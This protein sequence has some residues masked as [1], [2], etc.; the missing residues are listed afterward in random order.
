M[1]SVPGP[2]SGQGEVTVPQIID[3]EEGNASRPGSRGHSDTHL[4]SRYLGG[5]GEKTVNPK[6]AWLHSDS[7]SGK[8]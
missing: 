2:G 6:L 1:F 5:A 4:Q 3:S 8:K 7:I